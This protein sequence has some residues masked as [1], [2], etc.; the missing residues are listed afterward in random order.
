MWELKVNKEFERYYLKVEVK[1]WL[2]ANCTGCS[3]ILPIFEDG[4]IFIKKL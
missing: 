3:V 2:M 4:F 1:T